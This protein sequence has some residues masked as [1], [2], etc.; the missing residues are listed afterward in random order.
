M[1]ETAAHLVSTINLSLPLLKQITEIQA[2]TSIAPGKWSP[3]EIIGHL[4]DSAGNNQQKF[5]RC[6]E[7][8]GLYFPNYKQDFWVNNQYYKDEPWEQLLVLWENY[9]RHLAHLIGHIPQACRSHTINLGQSGKFTL[10]FIVKDY[11][12]H[13]KHH[14]KSLFPDADFLHNEFKMIY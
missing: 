4:I 3:K 12:E 10:E 2:T 5:I 9:N 14:L 8:D 1:N 13:L 6:M 7:Q 11:P